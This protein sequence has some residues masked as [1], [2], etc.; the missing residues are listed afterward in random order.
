MSDLTFRPSR[1]AAPF[2]GVASTRVTPARALASSAFRFAFSSSVFGFP[3][4]CCVWD[5]D[6]CR[7][8]LRSWNTRERL[9]SRLS[10]RLFVAPT[11][12]ARCFESSARA[13]LSDRVCDDFA[14]PCLDDFR[15]WACFRLRDG[16]AGFSA[17][18]AISSASE[19]T[20]CGNILERR[21]ATWSGR[22]VS[23]LSVLVQF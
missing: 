21:R 8:S 13:A 20:A 18:D 12:S 19:K 14:A 9:T 16:A 23:N 22:V 1:P 2:A 10:M 6:A 4:L 5:I 15:C 11:L 7:D 3:V 17:S